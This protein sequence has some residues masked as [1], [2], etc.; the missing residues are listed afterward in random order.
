MPAEQPP[1]VSKTA[2]QKSI[3]V[4]SSRPPGGSGVVGRSDFAFVLSVQYVNMGITHKSSTSIAGQN[5]NYS[6]I[7]FQC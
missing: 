6:C 3:P 2:L 1:K 5:F 4:S 7:R